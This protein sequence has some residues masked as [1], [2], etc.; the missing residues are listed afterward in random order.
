MNACVALTVTHFLFGML[1]GTATILTGDV[2]SKLVFLLALPLS[3]TMTIFYM[4]TVT[5][6]RLTME[7]LA[8]RRQGIKLLMYKRILI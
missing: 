6:L 8:T 4:W 5:G 1:Y 7:H 3:M 2:N